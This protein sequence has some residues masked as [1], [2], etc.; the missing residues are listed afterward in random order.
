MACFVPPKNFRKISGPNILTRGG[1]SPTSGFRFRAGKRGTAQGSQGRTEA[2][3]AVYSRWAAGT[4]GPAGV[5]AAVSHVW[6]AGEAAPA[7]W[8]GRHSGMV[9]SKNCLKIGRRKCKSTCTWHLVDR[10]GLRL[11]TPMIVNTIDRTVCSSTRSMASSSAFIV[12]LDFPTFRV[13]M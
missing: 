3:V 11:A 8:V 2:K 6:P 4:L 5:A 9:P 7:V 13:V 1:R 10:R 12:R